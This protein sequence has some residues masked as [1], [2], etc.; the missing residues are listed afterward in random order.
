MMPE[1]LEF[2]H[3][4]GGRRHDLWKYDEVP[5]GM[6]L[7]TLRDLYPGR[8][9]LYQCR[10]GPDTG[11]WYTGYFAGCSVEPLRW[12]VTTGIPVYVKDE[13]K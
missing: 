7:A 4:F 1:K 10:L 3:W 12:M 13:K 6:R 8:P 11:K 2:G 5:S 9:V